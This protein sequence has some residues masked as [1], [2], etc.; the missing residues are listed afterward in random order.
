MFAFMALFVGKLP[1]KNSFKKW[2]TRVRYNEPRMKRRGKKRTVARFT[3]LTL[4][5]QPL[6]AV[7]GCVC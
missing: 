5:A 1:A 4:A 7:V 6:P 2:L 3:I